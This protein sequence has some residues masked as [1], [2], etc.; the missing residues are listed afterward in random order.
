VPITSKPS[1]VRL[2]LGKGNIAYW[3]SNVSRGKV[4]FEAA[5]QKDLLLDPL[6]SAANKLPFKVKVIQR[7][8]FSALLK[9]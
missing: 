5:G 3:V 7:F 6:K 4:V 8:F 9:C 2:G 1:E